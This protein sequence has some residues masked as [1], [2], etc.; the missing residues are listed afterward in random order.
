MAMLRRPTFLER[1]LEASESNDASSMATMPPLLSREFIKLQQAAEHGT[2]GLCWPSASVMCRWLREHAADLDG[3]RV[4]ELGCGTGACGL[5]AAGLGASHVLLTDGSEEVIE[6]AQKNLALNREVLGAV[7]VSFAR[8]S[9]GTVIPLPAG[10]WDLILASDCIYGYGSDWQPLAKTIRALIDAQAAADD[11]RLPPRVILACSHR[12]PLLLS[13]KFVADARAHGL[14]V[15]GSDASRRQSTTGSYAPGG[16]RGICAGGA[17][18]DCSSVLYQG[19]VS[20][21]DII[22]EYK[23][24]EKSRHRRREHLGVRG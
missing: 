19:T 12:R 3:I 23:V 8:L 2:G 6:N 16:D 18:G 13:D 21:G 22:V 15:T 10:P 17:I 5:Y 11:D 1:M 24:K 14:G 9:F 4:L 20:E 7:D